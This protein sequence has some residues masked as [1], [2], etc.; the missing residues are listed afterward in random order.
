MEVRS[1]KNVDEETWKS[2]KVLATEN[3][4]KM[5]FLLKMMINEFKKNSKDFWRKILNGEKNLGE[6]EADDML[7]SILELR[8]EKGFRI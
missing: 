3:N 7:K 4:L 5:S 6:S 1:I 8:K 2:F